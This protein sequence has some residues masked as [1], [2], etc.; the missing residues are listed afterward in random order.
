SGR[1]GDLRDG[2]V[3]GRRVGGAI[4]P[5]APAPAGG[6]AA[7]AG[8]DRP[9]LRRCAHPSRPTSRGNQG[10]PCASRPGV[11]GRR[12]GFPPGVPRSIGMTQDELDPMDLE[13]R[14]R[15]SI[16]RRLAAVIVPTCAIALAWHLLTR[17]SAA[18]PPAAAHAAAPASV[19]IAAHTPSPTEAF[20]V[21][22]PR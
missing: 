1:A 7:G 2:D 21:D 12:P 4:C 3:A 17:P 5:L 18:E 6:A 19:E 22:G 10:R 15:R 8:R 20:E 14:P 9:I 16:P 13:Q 11:A